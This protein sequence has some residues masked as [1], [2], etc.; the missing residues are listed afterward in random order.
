M[1]EKTVS[2]KKNMIHKKIKKKKIVLNQ[3]SCIYVL[4]IIKRKENK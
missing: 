1:K 4:I 3:T 2:D